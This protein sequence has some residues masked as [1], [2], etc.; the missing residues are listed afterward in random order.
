M[1]SERRRDW[2]FSR[3]MRLMSLLLP[4]GIG[5]LDVVVDRM[6][7]AKTISFARHQVHKRSRIAL[8]RCRIRIGLSQ[9]PKSPLPV[10][11]LPLTRPKQLHTQPS[12]PPNMDHHQDTPTGKT[13]TPFVP[14]PPSPT[15]HAVTSSL[16]GLEDAVLT[17]RYVNHPL[18]GPSSSPPCSLSPYHPAT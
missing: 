7:Q 2:R 8:V 10:P 13:F 14:R 5:Q 12:L 17:V 18:P 4:E 16:R 15:I 11:R 6:D 3:S 9:F 1:R